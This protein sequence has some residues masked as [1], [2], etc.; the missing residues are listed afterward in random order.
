MTNDASQKNCSRPGFSRGAHDARG[1]ANFTVYFY[2]FL[3]I[4]IIFLLMTVPRRARQYQGK[5][6]LQG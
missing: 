2:H 1:Q 5:M 3:L 4:I 6:Y